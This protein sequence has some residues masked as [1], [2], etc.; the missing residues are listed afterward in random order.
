MEAERVQTQGNKRKSQSQKAEHG[1]WHQTWG[2]IFNHSDLDV[3]ITS[4][5]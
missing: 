3:A 2:E 5:I 4:H 1:L